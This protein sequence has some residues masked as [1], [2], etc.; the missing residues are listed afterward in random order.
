MTVRVLETAKR[1]TRCGCGALIEYE[2]RDAKAFDRG[3]A[4]ANG[5]Q[6]FA[7]GTVSIQ[8]QMTWPHVTCPDCH[9]QTMV[10]G[11]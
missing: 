4:L 5:M 8:A 11:V 6:P 1:Q 7:G 9:Q 3:A 10:S 2:P